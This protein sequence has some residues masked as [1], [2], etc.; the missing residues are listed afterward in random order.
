MRTLVLVALVAWVATANGAESSRAQSSKD[1]KPETLL[2]WSFVGTTE[3]AKNDK[4]TVFNKVRAL[5]ESA[6]MRDA[7]ATN[8]AR[9]IANRYSRSASS[10]PPAKLKLPTESGE[11]L[12]MENGLAALTRP[13]IEDL[14]QNESRFH[15]DSVGAEDAHWML[16]VRLP[17]NRVANW[18]KHLAQLASLSRM[19]GAD[20]TKQTWTATH[21]KYKLT[22]SR[23][24]DWTI[25]EGGLLEEN[26]K[27]SK[28]FRDAVGKRSGKTV[29]DAE[30]NPPLLG[31]I[32]SAPQLAH[33]PKFSLKAEPKNDGFLS[34]LLLDYP[35]DLGIKHEKW[36]IPTGLIQEPLISF[37]AIQGVRKKLESIEQFRS[38][39]AKQTPNQL[40]AWAQ[41]ISPFSVFLAA[42]VKNP[43][44]V[45][46]N[47]TRAAE[48]IKLPTGELQ[49]ATNRS[50]LLWHGLPIVVPYLEAAPNPHNG[51]VTA[52]LFPARLHDAKPAPAE[53]LKQLDQKN[54]VYYD[55]EIT[56]NRLEQW[57]PTW[58]L[59]Y[60]VNGQFIPSN[61]APSSRFLQAL[62][63][64]LGNTI[65]E[66]TLENPRRIKF[67]RHSHLGANALELTLLAHHFDSADLRSVGMRQRNQPA[68]S[69]PAPAP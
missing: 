6:V 24:K 7:I 11:A 39:G 54:L 37:T 58:Q 35:Q 45:V 19:T 59:F 43:A 47:A 62:K 9:T 64:Q 56:G 49:L 4:L 31:K 27:A 22:F 18:S 48:R 29:L 16:A 20:E 53:L 57:I 60:L 63:S 32:W 50:A 34:E 3:L 2:R 5:P 8:V 38:L 14:V 15:M 61:D 55:W 30:I 23:S 51:F 40:F 46:T 21:E 17:E 12:R 41:G 66:G 67:I 65:T 68:P 1:S 26:S 52:G 44:E 10:N 28:S 36:N 42:E 33:Y 25:I 13:L 69:V